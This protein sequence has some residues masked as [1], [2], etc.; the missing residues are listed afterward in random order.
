[1]SPIIFDRVTPGM[2]IWKDEIFAP[3]VSIKGSQGGGGCGQSWSL[4]FYL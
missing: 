3:F 4:Y 2:Q 1:M